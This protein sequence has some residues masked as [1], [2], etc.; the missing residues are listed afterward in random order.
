MLEKTLP[1]LPPDWDHLHAEDEVLSLAAPENSQEQRNPSKMMFI[2]ASSCAE[3]ELL[4]LPWVACFE[5]RGLKGTGGS[6]ENK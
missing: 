6:K 4:S 1:P 5:H 3:E 2:L